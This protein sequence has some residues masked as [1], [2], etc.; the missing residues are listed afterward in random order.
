[1]CT[2]NS[3]YKQI[4]MDRNEIIEFIKRNIKSEK[5]KCEVEEA[6]I[7]AVL[8]II[9]LL[10]HYEEEDKKIN[11]S[12]AIGMD[13]NVEELIAG[14]YVLKKSE[15]LIQENIE[16][17]TKK[18]ER[19]IKQVAVFC[20]KDANIFLVQ[21]ESTIECGIYIPKLN[22]TEETEKSFFNNNFI[23]FESI[24][25][26]RVI[27]NAGKECL[28]IC[29]DFD[30]NKEM[31]DIVNDNEL[32]GDPIYMKWK[33]IFERVKRSVHGTICLIVDSNWDPKKDEN[34]TSFIE[35]V[36]LNLKIKSNPSADEIQNFN[37]Q[38]DM[39]LA[40]LNFD[41][42]TII[43]TSERIRAYNLFCRISND[44][45]GNMNG[46]A[47]HK[48]YESLKNLSAGNRDD[49][50]AI[51]F[52]S[53]EG[54]IEFYEFHDNGQGQ[55]HEEKMSNDGSDKICIEQNLKHYFNPEVMKPKT[56][57]KWEDIKKKYK[58]IQVSCVDEFVHVKKE[59]LSCYVALYNL[60]NELIEAHNGIDNFYNEPKNAHNLKEYIELNKNDVNRVLSLY[61]KMRI[62]LLSI[63]FQCYIGHP[64]GY[65]WDAQKYLHDII[66]LVDENVYEA[67]FKNEEYIDIQ[68]IWLLSSSLLFERWNS[69]LSE[70]EERYPKIFESIG[71]NKNKNEY[72][73]KDYGDMYDALTYDED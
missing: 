58:E 70:I 45:E 28:Y 27:A 59:D 54:E 7:E 30:K 11:F 19:M 39:F 20:E 26:N 9:P 46:G 4:K 25:K 31:E 18:I 69:I 65:S 66:N 24:Y 35:E 13:N 43:D 44:K 32:P 23:I 62:E 3:K 64:S 1:M 6:L 41:G 12:I 68:L 40:M 14:S 21:K 49:Y 34:F 72:T 67:Y 63:V 52:Q 48:A 60:V 16:E 38:L 71:E 55:L 8:H 73:W 53:Q 61:T 51:Y 37:N 47:R 2:L 10:G 22:I 5:K 56:S 15:I 29:M 36:D 42:I 57:T 33:G 17:R 50:V